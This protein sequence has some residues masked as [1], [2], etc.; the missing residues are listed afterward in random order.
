M[1]GPSHLPQVYEQFLNKLMMTAIH[2]CELSMF[3]ENAYC[4]PPVT[5]DTVHNDFNMDIV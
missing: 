2:C 4:Q 5:E 3:R 1:Q